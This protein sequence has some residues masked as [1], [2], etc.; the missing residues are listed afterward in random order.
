MRYTIMPGFVIDGHIYYTSQAQL[1]PPSTQYDNLLRTKIQCMINLPHLN[2]LDTITSQYQS[3]TGLPCFITPCTHV[4]GVKLSI[5]LCRC[6]HCRMHN[7]SVNIGDKLASV[8]FKSSGTAYKHLFVGHHSHA[9]RPCPLCTP[10]CFLLMHT[11]GFV[12]R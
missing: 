4:Q 1:K 11:T 10:M 3:I 5:Q 9:H 8:C 7:E 12:C 6:H 2:L